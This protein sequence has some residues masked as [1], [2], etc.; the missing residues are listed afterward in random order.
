MRRRRRRLAGDREYTFRHIR[1]LAR[2]I[3]YC[4]KDIVKFVD[5][6]VLRPDLLT[7]NEAATMEQW[8]EEAYQNINTIVN[9]Q[10]FRQRG[11]STRRRLAREPDKSYEEAKQTALYKIEKI[12]N[13]LIEDA[14]YEGDIHEPTLVWHSNLSKSAWNLVDM[15]DQW[16]IRR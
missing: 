13:D 1:Q 7:D 8:L 5:R 12:M 4:A 11:G 9:E 2:L 3:E 6:A 15:I 10:K 16:K 14:V